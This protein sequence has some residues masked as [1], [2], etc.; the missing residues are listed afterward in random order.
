MLVPRE[1]SA[2]LGTSVPVHL[3]EL[4][5]LPIVL[6]YIVQGRSQSPGDVGEMNQGRVPWL[7][8]PL[9]PKMKLIF[10]TYFIFGGPLSGFEW[11]LSGLGWDV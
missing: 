5:Y 2:G 10:F 11:G 3:T 1:E 6:M 8:G 4:T 7:D 9:P